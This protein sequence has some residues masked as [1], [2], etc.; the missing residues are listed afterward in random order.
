M[1]QF[2]YTYSNGVE[3]FSRIFTLEEIEQG[4]QFDEVSDSP[5]LKDY[6]IIGRKLIE[7]IEVIGYSSTF[8]EASS[9]SSKIKDNK[10]K[11]RNKAIED[12]ISYIAG[13][14]N[15]CVKEGNFHCFI[16]KS[17]AFGVWRY[18]IE[19]VVYS[20][21]KGRGYILNNTPDAGGFNINIPN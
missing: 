4:L 6:K 16:W 14:I 2:K 15:N 1:Y 3:E 11:A 17:I 12:A 20:L 9:L 7:N 10:L 21:L 8:T 5:L 19:E 18:S 13:E